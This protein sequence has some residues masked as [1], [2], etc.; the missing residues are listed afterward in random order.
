M[1]HTRSSLPSTGL[2]GLTVT[3]GAVGAVLSQVIQTRGCG[4]GVGAIIRG[5]GNRNR[6]SFVKETGSI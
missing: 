1:E 6:L 4:G 2:E 3:V 5:D